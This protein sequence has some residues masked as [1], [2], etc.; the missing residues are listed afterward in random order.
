MSQSVFTIAI[1]HKKVF[2]DYEL[3]FFRNWRYEQELA[4]LIWKIDPK[5]IQKK[6]ETAYSAISIMSNNGVGIEQ[7]LLLSCSRYYHMLH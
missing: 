4:S 1:K 3:L 2:F 6:P 7:P 5:E